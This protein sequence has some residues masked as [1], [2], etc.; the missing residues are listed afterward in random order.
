M[1]AE[2]PILRIS[3]P[4]ERGIRLEIAKLAATSTD[5]E[6]DLVDVAGRITVLGDSMRVDLRRVALPHSLLS[7]SGNL[8]WPT[9]PLLYDLVV[10]ADSGTLGDVP[11]LNLKFPA[12]GVLRGDLRVR[13][14][15]ARLLEV[16]L[17][18]I[19]V[20]YG[21]G[22][23]TGRLTTVSVSD[24]GLVAVRDADLVAN[25]FALDFTRDV[26]PGLPFR[27]RVTGHATA[28][29]TLSALALNVDIVFRD[30]LVPGWPVTAI[31]GQGRV[32]LFEPEGIGFKP[33]TLD[34]MSADLGSV[35]RLV[36]GV[37]LLGRVDAQGTLTGTLHNTAFTGTLVHRDGSRPESVIR[38]DVGLDTRRD[39]VVFSADVR[40]DS[41][42]FEDLRGSFPN[43]LLRGTVTGPIKLAGTLGALDTHF[44]LESARGGGAVRLD[45]TLT[46]LDERSG[47]RD[48]AFQARHLNLARWVANGPDSRLSFTVAGDVERVD[49]AP[50]TGAFTAVLG[51][52]VIAGTELDSGQ[53]AIRLADG[54]VSVDSLRLAQPE[55]VTTGTGTLGW[56]RPTHG[57]LVFTISADSLNGLDSLLAWMAGPD[58]V[59]D[60][61]SRSLHGSAHV[62]VAVDGA[63]D[64]LALDEHGSTEHFR[65]RDWGIPAGQVRAGYEPG[66]V[67]TFQLEATLDSLRYGTYGFGAVSAAVRGRRDSVSWFAR[68]RLGDVSAVLA[69]GRV[70]RGEPSPGGHPATAV[71]LDSLALLL[72]GG[73]WVLKEPARVTISDSTVA[74]GTITLQS[75]SDSGRVIVRGDIPTRGPAAAQLQIEGF[76]LAG[77]YALSRQDTTGVAGSLTATLGLTGTRATPV[78]EGSLAISNGA[79][80]AFHAPY[81]DGTFEYR[82]RRLNAA[83]HLWRSGQQILKVD[84]RLPLDLS[85]TTVADRR[86]PDSLSVRARADSVDLSVLGALTTLVQEV[87]GEFSAD[88][89]IAGTWRS[90]RLEGSVQIAGGAATIPALNVRYDGIAGRLSMSADTI[91]IGALS[92]R[93]DKGRLDVAGFIRLEQLRRPV[94]GLQIT[95]DRFNGLDL[96]GNLS[97]T[98][99]GRLALEGPVFGATLTGEATVTSGVVYFADL[100]EKRIV[101]LD[102]FGDT[103]LASLIQQQGLGPEFQSVF[104]DSVRIRAL[105]L[106]MGSD[107]WL[108]SSEANIQLT[109]T[110]TL[111][112]EGKQYLLSGT[113]QAPRGTYR[114][115]IGPVTRE[116]VVTRG[117]VRYFANPDLNADVESEARHTVHPAP[118]PAQ[119]SPPDVTIVAHIGGTLSVPKVTLQSENGDMSDTE[120]IS[121]LLFGRSS[122]DIGNGQGG[123]LTDQRAILQSA[124]SVLSG[125]IERTLVSDLGIPLDYVE[126]RPGSSGDPF[127]GVQ[128]A[129]GRQLGSRTF[130]VVNAGFCQGRA[131]AVGNTIGLSLEYRIN[132]EF[133]TQA[134][135]EPVVN[136]DPLLDTQLTTPLRQVG[137]DLIWERRY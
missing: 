95:G 109:G 34:S 113:L 67:P 18:P 121:Y 84:A 3:S 12:A 37:T 52:S 65:W 40:A 4:Q 56:R 46:L 59:S 24:S 127:S 115:K 49:S 76:P 50:P 136:C 107:V 91:S 102:Q 58:R 108:R 103:A 28:D 10:H 116:L 114:L 98:A 93:S 43:L 79:L 118:T 42:S 133:R 38:G 47:A 13:S 1:N 39:T 117:T 131:I 60:T 122:L 63:L 124:V 82:D 87:E 27:G 75:V 36:P 45:G 89:G 71:A 78:Y 20:R 101:D 62:Q 99:S 69:G 9:G 53:A 32:D 112:K 30:S 61:P 85:L 81:V 57:A 8:R 5:P 96:K 86:L 132:L 126:I 134:S 92:A 23:L 100:L 97:V 64:S 17:A 33:F 105:S 41:V 128:L 73:V 104:L 29:G 48:L 72:P 16:G 111:S 90:P 137:F 110:V 94:L 44:D 130:L 74:L 123:G 19:D 2:L 31:R 21:G 6:V 129:L 68:S 55:I 120:A 119:R 11:F 83:V 77:V 66:P 15:G 7:G 106:T 125:E 54:M 135:F 70:I 35:R 51:P 26:V 80:G 14:H 25:D 88:V 22:T